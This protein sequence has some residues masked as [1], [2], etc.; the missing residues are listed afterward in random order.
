MYR[1]DEAIPVWVK[2]CCAAAQLAGI[3]PKTD[4]LQ[5]SAPITAE[6]ANEWLNQTLALTEISYL[7]P[8][9]GQTQAYLNL[10]AHGIP[11]PAG[12]DVLTRGEAA[13][14]LAAALALK[15]K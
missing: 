1:D 3:A 4:E 6:E 12:A 11:A 8:E 15:S 10:T 2:G 5:A 13:R 7:Q 14:M 9:P